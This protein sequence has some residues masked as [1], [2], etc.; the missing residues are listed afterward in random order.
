MNTLPEVTALGE[1]EARR[2][3]LSTP[4]LAH[5]EG[6]ETPGVGGSRPSLPCAGGNPGLEGGGGSLPGHPGPI[7]VPAGQRPPPY[8]ARGGATASPP[9]PGSCLQ[10]WS[11]LHFPPREVPGP[12]GG[13]RLQAGH[14][15]GA[16]HRG[17]AAAM[18]GGRP[19]E[20]GWGEIYRLPHLPR[21][22]AL[23]PRPPATLLEPPPP[24]P[25]ARPSLPGA[26]PRQSPPRSPPAIGRRLPERPAAAASGRPACH[27]AA[28]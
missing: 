1:R 16:Q 18:R 4:H 2:C 23:L 27:L 20:Q 7:S 24:P 9:A 8:L 28:P 13:T 19:A 10:L 5:L 6:S 3:H 26:H 21:P 14:P 12:R 17:A 15:E 22:R 25:A 11:P